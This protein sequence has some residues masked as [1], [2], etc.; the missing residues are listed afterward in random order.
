[1][2]LVERQPEQ[3]P[4]QRND[5]ERGTDGNEQLFAGLQGLEPGL[6]APLSRI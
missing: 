1:M 3:A 2:T 6:H 4:D 5:D